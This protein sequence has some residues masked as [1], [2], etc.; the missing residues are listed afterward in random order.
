LISIGPVL[1][2]GSPHRQKKAAVAVGHSILVICWHPLAA[3]SDYTDLG[4]DYFTTSPKGPTPFTRRANPGRRRD[5]LI[6]Q[7]TGLGY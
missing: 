3:D 2:A 1:A 4:G 7:L 6:E 5:R